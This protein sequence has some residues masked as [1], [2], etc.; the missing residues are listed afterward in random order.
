MVYTKPSI[1]LTIIFGIG[2]VISGALYEA[3]YTTKMTFLVLEILC[4]NLSHMMK[5]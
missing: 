1:V 4:S 2:R 5:F 3:A